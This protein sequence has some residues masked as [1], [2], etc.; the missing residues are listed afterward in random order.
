MSA[1]LGSEEVAAGALGCVGPIK[2]AFSPDGKRSNL[3]AQLAFVI[4]L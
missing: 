3:H 1:Q 2:V 4:T